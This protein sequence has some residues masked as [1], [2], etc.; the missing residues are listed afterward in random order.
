[1]RDNHL[2]LH[3][4]FQLM[5]MHHMTKTKVSK[6]QNRK[7][8]QTRRMIQMTKMIPVKRMM[9]PPCH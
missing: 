1:M 7:V 3:E 4:M 2:H 9:R 5:Q 8:I 6:T